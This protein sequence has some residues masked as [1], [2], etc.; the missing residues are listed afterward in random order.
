[1]RR[2][3]AT[4]RVTQSNALFVL[5]GSVS[6]RTASPERWRAYRRRFRWGQAPKITEFPCLPGRPSGNLT[7]PSRW[8]SCPQGMLHDRFGLPCSPACCWR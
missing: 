7:A 8:L 5:S 4:A 3:G 1:M 2:T 6:R